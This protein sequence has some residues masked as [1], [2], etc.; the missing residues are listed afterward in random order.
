MRWRF[1][2]KAT[3]VLSTTGISVHG[4]LKRKETVTNTH[5]NES[6]LFNIILNVTWYY[7][8]VAF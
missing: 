8:F 2:R 1:I 6:I 4:N 5:T 3:I 7:N